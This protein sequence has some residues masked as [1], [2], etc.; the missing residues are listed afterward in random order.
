MASAVLDR[1]SAMSPLEMPTRLVMVTCRGKSGAHLRI[2]PALVSGTSASIASFLCMSEKTEMIKWS[3]LKNDVKYILDLVQEADGS[4]M[5]L[6]HEL[7]DTAHSNAVLESNA[8]LGADLQR[9]ANSGSLTDHVQLRDGSSFIE[10]AHGGWMTKA[11]FDFW[12]LS[13]EEKIVIPPE[14]VPW[15]NGLPP[16][17][18]SK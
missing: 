13:P 1:L 15:V 6:L 3:Q 7:G 18:P 8:Y 17:F 4:R 2:S 5:L 16:A 10:E 9:W 11:E 14:D 12:R